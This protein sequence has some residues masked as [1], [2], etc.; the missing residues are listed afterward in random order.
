MT[1]VPVPGTVHLVDLEGTSNRQHGDESDIILIPQPT[2]DPNDPLNWSSMRRLTASICHALWVLFGAI[3][4]NGLTV[5]YLAIE[6]DTSITMTDLNL[7]NGLM[8]LFFGW[9]SL[10]SQPLALTFGRRVPA[11]VSFFVTSFFILWASFMKSAAEWYANR[12][13]I[14]IFF[15]GIESLIELCI[16]DTKFIHERGLHVGLY[17]WSL[18]AGAFLSPIPAGFLASAAGWR[19]INVM[20]FIVGIV[21]TVFMF[22][23]FEETMFYRSHTADEFLDAAPS[24]ATDET[25]AASSSCP[26]SDKGNDLAVAT[27]HESQPPTEETGEAY[28]VRPFVQRLKLTSARDARQPNAFKF[29]LLPLQLMRYPSI[30]FSGV[31]IGGVLAWFNVFTGTMALVFGNAPYDFSTNMIGLTYLACLIG[32]SFGCVFAGWFTDWV[33][34]FLARRNNGIKEPEARLWAALIPLVLHPA[35]CVLY[36]VG[37]AHG[38]HWVGLCFGLGLV[39]FG[40]VMGSTLALSY[41]VDCYREVAGEAIVS[42]IVIRNSIGQ[43][44]FVL[45]Q[46]RMRRRKVL[47]DFRWQGSLSVMRSLQ[48]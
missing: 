13:L 47:T 1:S 2:K 17:N 40:I 26:T 43:S 6:K 10:L 35:G 32:A 38:V 39:T 20:Y 12:I 27:S 37:A 41:C 30:L 21:T 3:I 23:F 5:A 46:N 31:L 42:I 29:V 4:I 19:W 14:G 15:S 22:L 11:V 8:Y 36:G 33:A 7:G 16:T 25:K 24:Q 48:W 18:Y 45:G 34:V 28:R 9:G 44:V